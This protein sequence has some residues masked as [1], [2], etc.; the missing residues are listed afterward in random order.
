M[1]KDIKNK[2]RESK[3]QD[4]RTKEMIFINWKNCY[5]GDYRISTSQ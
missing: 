4:V 3:V 1:T 2:V 5:K